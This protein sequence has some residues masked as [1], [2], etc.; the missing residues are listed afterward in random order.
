MPERKQGF[1][2]LIVYRI[3]SESVGMLEKGRSV[4]P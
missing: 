4:I 3:V 2:G 1:A